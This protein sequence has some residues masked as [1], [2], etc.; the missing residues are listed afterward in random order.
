MEMFQENQR[1]EMFQKITNLTKQ[2]KRESQRK[3]KLLKLKQNIRKMGIKKES[4]TLPDT[5][6]MSVT[7]LF[8]GATLGKTKRK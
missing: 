4:Y 7:E 6:Q 8:E 1:Q 3:E 5:F 2:T